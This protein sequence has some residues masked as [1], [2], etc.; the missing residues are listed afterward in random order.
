MQSANGTTLCLQEN[1]LVLKELQHLFF[2]LAVSLDTGFVPTE[3][4]FQPST[5][6]SM[7]TPIDYLDF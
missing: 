6:T 7:W 5:G 2:C 1:S 4:T 3:T